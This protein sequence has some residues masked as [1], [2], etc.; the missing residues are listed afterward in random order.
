MTHKPIQIKNLSLVFPHKICF[1]NFNAQIHACDRIAII[2]RNGS[3]KS[4]LL[5][6]LQ[7]LVEPSE[8]SIYI[9]ND[10]HLA[11]V[12]QV[13]D[14]FDALSG[15]QRF[16]AALTQALSQ[17]PNVLLLDEPTNHLDDHN[18]KSLLRLLKNYE[19]TL[20][21]ITHDVELLNNGMNILWHIDFGKINI[22]SGSYKDYL[23]ELHVMRHAIEDEL[24]QLKR[25]KQDMHQQLMKEQI[26]AKSSKDRGEKS[27]SQRKW[28]TIVSSSKARRA[29]E[30]SGRKK[31]D[32]HSKKEVLLDKLEECRLPE[33]IKPK[34]S[35]TSGAIA[36]KILVS[37]TDASVGYQEIILKDINLSLRG[38]EHLAIIGPNGSGKSTLVKAIFNKHELRK[39]GNW[40]L[41]KLE[42]MGYLDQ[43]YETLNPIKTVLETLENLVPNWT[44]LEIRRHL[45]DFLFR[46]NEEV[47]ARVYSLSGGEKARLS[48]ACIAAKTPKLLILDEITN[49]LDLESKEH[50]IQILKKYSGAMIIISHDSDFI[51]AIGVERHL[52]VNNKTTNL[53]FQ[54]KEEYLGAKSI[55][56]KT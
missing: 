7:A 23:H 41:P 25:Q 13:I 45:T 18:R 44:S 49:N 27:I 20:I 40:Q 55:I 10:V 19:G 5:K 54:S 34:F 48:L 31:S 17:K 56:K 35:I 50:V 12:P 14:E 39:S 51:N 42:D 29:E 15:G 37:I 28:P 9:P 26:R 6:M 1:E 16:N 52:D 32:I 2:G 30:T 24:L 36:S 33:I 8:G 43:H 53:K 3:G 47:N 21:V 38:D 4:T 11:Y 22:F 46:K